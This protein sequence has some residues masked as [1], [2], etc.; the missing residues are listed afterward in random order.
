MP[1]YSDLHI[2]TVNNLECDTQQIINRF[3]KLLSPDVTIKTLPASFGFGQLPTKLSKFWR[4]DFSKYK[5]IYLWRGDDLSSHVMIGF[6]CKNI[7]QPL[8]LVDAHDAIK[9][10]NRLKEF[11]IR[12]SLKRTEIETHAI[13]INIFAYSQSPSL[14][15]ATLITDQ[16]R[17]Q[18]INTW[19]NLVATDTGLRIFDENNN[20][21]N[22]PEDYFDTAILQT[23]KKESYQNIIAGDYN[24]IFDIRG[25][26]DAL[27]CYYKRV[28]TLARQ[29]KVVLKQADSLA[30][31][32]K[33]YHIDLS[34]A[35]CVNGVYVFH[36]PSIL[37]K[38][39]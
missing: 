32:C 3:R 29:N 4:I 7:A 14:K 2:L 25:D 33:S 20:V 21:I 1:T 31:Y 28:I 35:D 11:T 36:L 9:E 27:I 24:P 12:R 5:N 13:K 23:I 34:H 10:F 15:N 8:M 19:D 39:P 22:V 18:Y 6:L 16:Q 26:Y 30:E 38:L 17:E 37:V